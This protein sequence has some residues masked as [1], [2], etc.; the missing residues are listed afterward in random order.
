MK[1]ILVV[2]DEPIMRE[3]I[4]QIF[5]FEGYDVSTAGDGEEAIM[6]LE[7]LRPAL[8]LCDLGMPKVDGYGV[9]SWVRQHAE[10]ARTP[11]LVLTAYRHDGSQKRAEE[12]GCDGYLTKPFDIDHLLGEVAR[13]VSR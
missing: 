8:I 6:R 4:A 2:E 10:L 11:F 7:T 1:T 3:E 9:L 5:E 12:L 13:F